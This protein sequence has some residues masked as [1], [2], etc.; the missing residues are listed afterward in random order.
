MPKSQ[1][2]HLREMPSD[3]DNNGYNGVGNELLVVRRQHGLDL[4]TVSRELRIQYSHLDAIETG[5]FE[6]LPGPAYAIGFLRSYATYLEIDGE[7][8]VEQF[9]RESSMVPT[10]TRFKFPEPVDE[11]RRPG[12]FV[13]VASVAMIAL[14]YGGWSYLQEQHRVAVELVPNP[15]ERLSALLEAEEPPAIR[16][17]TAPNVVSSDRLIGSAD[18][19]AASEAQQDVQVASV[20]IAGNREAQ[21]EAA[22]DAAAAQNGH[23]NSEPLAASSMAAGPQASPLSAQAAVSGANAP[24][25]TTSSDPAT[26]TDPAPTE[27]QAGGM[28]DPARIDERADVE[29]Q[30]R[31]PLIAAEGEDQLTAAATLPPTMMRAGPGDADAPADDAAQST[32]DGELEV[33]PLPQLQAAATPMAAPRLAVQPPPTAPISPTSSARNRNMPQVY[34]AGNADARVVVRARADSWVQVQGPNN[35]LLLTRMLRAGDT[36]RA[37]NRIDLVMLTGNAGALEI[38]VDGVPLG[39]IGKIG[40]IRRGVSLSP[41]VLR[42]GPGRQTAVR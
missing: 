17:E 30:E 41:D 11:A 34:G 19:N 35:E 36:Y 5:R 10:P 18:Q 24:L 40:Q 39:P 1:R 7:E 3:G 37:P 21:R 4:D 23:E 12:K 15:P 33:P 28:P 26:E 31:A 22:R 9:K 16:P 20:D 13:L 32:S 29:Y 42:K 14:V 2:L 6:D 38:I 8:L 25:T 27:D